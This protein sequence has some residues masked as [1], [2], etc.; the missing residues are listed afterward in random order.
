MATTTVPSLPHTAQA[1]GDED[2]KSDYVEDVNP[3]EPAE[4]YVAPRPP[5]DYSSV[6]AFCASLWRRFCSLWTKRFILSL[7][8]HDVERPTTIHEL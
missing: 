2:R 3:S 1:L 4:S 8:A 6:G 7:I 5:I